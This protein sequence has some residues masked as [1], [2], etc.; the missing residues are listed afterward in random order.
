MKKIFASLI[1]CAA[2]ALASCGDSNYEVHQTFFSPLKNGGMEF[3]AD[4]QSDTIHLLSLDSWTLAS[5][6]SWMSVTPTSKNIPQYQSAD[7]R[8]DITTEVNTTGATRIA[9]INVTANVSPSM[10]V[11]QRPWLNIKQPTAFYTDTDKESTKKA[12]F[13]LM[14]KAAA[15]DTTLIFKVY[16]DGA[17]LSSSA[18]WVT[19]D[20]TTF[21]SG[22][23][24]VKVSFTANSTNAKR[25]ATLTL[26]SA[27][28]S[29]DIIVSQDK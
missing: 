15:N 25:N 9:Y 24:K 14:L 16:Q 22:L 21:K 6:A 18:D 26:T 8:L 3:F 12:T 23:H 17:T 29:T 11:I 20:S 13:P 19:P 28:V 1:P 2:L 7:T 27:G 10:P 5:T 4:Q